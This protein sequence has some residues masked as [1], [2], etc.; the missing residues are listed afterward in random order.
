MTYSVKQLRE[1]ISKKMT[2]QHIY[3]PVMLRTLIRKGGAATTREIAAAFLAKDESQL[4]Y[5]ET[6]TKRMPGKVLASHGVVEKTA[7]GYRLL[8]DVSDLKK[9]QREE[10]LRLCDQRETAYLERRGGALYDH[11][12]AALGYIPGSL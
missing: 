5:Y 11:R 10:L 8:V 6:I 3:Q 12:R 1:F 7:D 2:M 9:E 4:E